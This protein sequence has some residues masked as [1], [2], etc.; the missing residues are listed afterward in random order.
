M[1]NN[2]LM[3]AAA[4]IL[5][6]SKGKNGAPMEKMPGTEVEDLGGPTPQNYKS[7]DDSAKIHAGKGTKSAVAPTT[8]PS[9]ASAKMEE[10]EN[11]SLEELKEFMV[12]E[13]F[14]QLD[15]LSKN[16]LRSYLKGSRAE[17]QGSLGSAGHMSD[18]ARSLGRTDD[19]KDDGR[20]EGAKAAKKRL[21][22][23]KEDIDALFADDS[24][25]SEEFKSKVSTI[26]EARVADRVSQIEEETE[27]K[28][29]GM[30]EEAVESIRADL[31]EKVDDYLSYVVE[32]WMKDNEI[33]IESGLRSELTEDFIAGMRNLFAEHYI[34][35]PAEKVDL[36]DELAG[37]VEELESKLNEEIERAVDLKKSLVESRKVEMTREVCEG[38]TDT[39][40]EKIK[41]LA[42]SVE[43]STEDEYK[44]KLDTI[45]ENYFPS[46]AKKATESQLNEQ[47]EETEEKKVIH[48]PFVA[49]VSQAISKTKF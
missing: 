46:G 22:A 38:L 44:S 28:Y 25:I 35:V 23:M 32:Q 36:V 43:F 10:I 18:K 9:D 33:A 34:D 45:R 13:E 20:Y 26:F 1:S 21:N 48:D 37:K 6:S 3:E 17:N 8:K 15:E 41:S 24:T 14:E 29:A 31:T 49:A 40:V 16:T 11:Y 12:S 7:D 39:Q 42:E 4:D 27:A 47:F 2:K 5:A 30:L 19:D